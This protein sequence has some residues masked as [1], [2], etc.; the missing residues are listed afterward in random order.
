MLRIGVFVLPILLVLGFVLT[1][2]KPLGPRLVGG[3]INVAFTLW[4]V[5]LLRKT[6]PVQTA[7]EMADLIERFLG[8]RSHYPQEWNDFVECS[9][10]DRQLDSYRKRCDELDPIVNC[11]E[12]PDPKALEELRNMVQELRRRR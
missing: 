4:F 3:T 11:L 10:P 5:Y 2:G 7:S 6:E 12:P 1:T 9:H 8:N